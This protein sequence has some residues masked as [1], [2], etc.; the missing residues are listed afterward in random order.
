MKDII[1]VLLRSL[2]GYFPILL[3]L[4]TGPKT[5]VL[6]RLYGRVDL[7][8]FRSAPSARLGRIAAGCDIAARPLRQGAAAAA[9]T[10]TGF[11]EPGRTAQ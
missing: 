5:T 2:R 7:S 9:L 6:S 4:V 10:S 8:R 3:A 11:V 1:E